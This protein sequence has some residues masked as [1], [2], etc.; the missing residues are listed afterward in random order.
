MDKIYLYLT[1]VI[2][3]LGV[4]IGA[5]LQAHFAKKNY[6]FKN[7]SE[8]QNKAYA[9]FLKSASGIAVAQRAGDR[10]KVTSELSNLADAKARICVYGHS[11]VIRELAVFMRSGG[12]LQTESEILSFTKLCIT[13]RDEVGMIKDSVVSTDISQLLFSIDVKDTPTPILSDC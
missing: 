5:Y 1:P 2:G 12:T 3:L 9:D 7:L 10:D 4:C 13:I 8:F 6:G 11:A